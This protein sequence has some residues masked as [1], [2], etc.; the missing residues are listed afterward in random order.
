MREFLHSINARANWRA[1]IL[2]AAGLSALLDRTYT[3]SR[4]TL[5]I[6]VCQPG[7]VAFQRASVSGDNLM[8]IATFDSGD[9][10]RPRGLSMVAAVRVAK[11]FGKT[12]FAGRALA[13]ISICHSG[14]SR[15]VFSRLDRFFISLQ[16]LLVSFTQTDDLRFSLAACEQ[17]AMQVILHKARGA[18][19]HRASPAAPS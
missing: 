2:R 1:L 16:L 11:I 14:L 19:I 6:R 7:P 9:F 8:L 3:D 18:Q 13:I 15:L 17:H 4:R 5:A 12:S 10:G